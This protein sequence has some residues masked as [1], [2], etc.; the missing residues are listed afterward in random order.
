M[1]GELDNFLRWCSAT[2]G[3]D[4][5]DQF[6]RSMTDARFP[7]PEVSWWIAEYKRVHQ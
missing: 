4:H 7:Y 3:T 6:G 2:A 1:S 5:K